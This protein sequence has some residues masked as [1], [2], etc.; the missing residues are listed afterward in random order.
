[1]PLLLN[2]SHYTHAGTA[3]SGQTLL[4]RMC[5]FVRDW[6]DHSFT[7]ITIVRAVCVYQ[8]QSREL[9]LQI[10]NNAL[11]SSVQNFY[12]RHFLYSENQHSSGSV[13]W[14][15]ISC[16]TPDVVSILLQCCS[17]LSQFHGYCWGLLYRLPCSVWW[18][19]DGLK[20]PTV[21]RSASTISK[22]MVK[23]NHTQTTLSFS[24]FLLHF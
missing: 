19:V 14:L 17:T 2:H 6:F 4:V 24:L 15:S 12:L 22:K 5:V 21:Q 7:M 11:L 23:L 1:M 3:C 20:L 10:T 9:W 13:P 16:V 18:G 8:Q